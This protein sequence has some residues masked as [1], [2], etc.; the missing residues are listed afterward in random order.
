MSDATAIEKHDPSA[1]NKSLRK[2]PTFYSLA[3][4][5]RSRGICLQL[6]PFEGSLLCRLEV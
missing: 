2:G 4:S 3:V 1:S 6:I 5:R